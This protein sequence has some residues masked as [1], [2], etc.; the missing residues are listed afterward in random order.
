MLAVGVASV[1]I[2]FLLLVVKKFYGEELQSRA[3]KWDEDVDLKTPKNE[4]VALR[5]FLN[6]TKNRQD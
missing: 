1:V 3:Q 4:T 5:G 2:Y 6:Q